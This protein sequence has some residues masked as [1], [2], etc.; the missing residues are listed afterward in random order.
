MANDDTKKRA[1]DEELAGIDRAAVVLYS[2]G[3]EAA[4]EVMR[5]LDHDNV[6]DIS[7]SMTSLP[8]ISSK[9]VEET[10]EEFYN[11]ISNE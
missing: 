7:K 6:R 8:N 11:M 3:E 2:I 5:F 9:V 10:I 1:A 4:T